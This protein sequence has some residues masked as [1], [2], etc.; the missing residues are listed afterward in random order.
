MSLEIRPLAA[1]YPLSSKQ[2]LQTD[3]KGRHKH[4]ATRRPLRSQPYL[5]YF[6]MGREWGNLCCQ[7]SNF[8]G[9]YQKRSWNRLLA[10]QAKEY[11]REYDDLKE[12][13][14]KSLKTVERLSKEL[15][16]AKQKNNA[17]EENA[18]SLRYIF[19]QIDSKI[20]S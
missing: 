13:L 1:L 16:Q 17:I 7:G 3:R 18:K 4:I 14:M 15:E 12:N 2:I 20:D 19:R 11:T 9:H 8:K 10:K 6:G 5:E